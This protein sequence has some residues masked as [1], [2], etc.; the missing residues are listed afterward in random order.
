L[1]T[2][3][4]AAEFEVTQIKEKF[5]GLRFYVRSGGDEDTYIDAR[6]DEGR[7]TILRRADVGAGSPMPRVRELVEAAMRRSEA[8]CMTCGE[9]GETGTFGAWVATLCERHAAERRARQQ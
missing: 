2:D 3:D 6:S 1:L 5:G 8:T 7:E 9:P 4:A